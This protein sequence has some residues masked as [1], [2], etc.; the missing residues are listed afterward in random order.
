MLLANKCVTYDRYPR[1]TF[2]PTGKELTYPCWF[3]GKLVEFTKREIAIIN[4][5]TFK[6]LPQLLK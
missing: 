3:K 6:E 4:S 1:P 5:R 2:S